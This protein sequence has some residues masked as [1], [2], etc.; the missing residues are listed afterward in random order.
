MKTSD[1]FFKKPE[2][3]RCWGLCSSFPGA[4]HGRVRPV[5]VFSDGSG[6]LMDTGKDGLPFFYCESAIDA[7]REIG[8][9]VEVMEVEL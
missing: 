8:F 3:R 1:E 2:N 5:T 4:C 7:D 6:S 9:R